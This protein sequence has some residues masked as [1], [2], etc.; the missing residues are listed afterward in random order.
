MT[1]NANVFDGPGLPLFIELEQC[2]FDLAVR[3]GELW[4]RPVDQLTG[5]QQAKIQ[6]HRDELVALVQSYDEGVQERLVAYKQQL[7][8]VPKGSTTD[9]VFQRGTPYAK[10][11]CFSCGAT[12][13][14]LQHG[15]CWRCS[16][17][18]RLAVGGGDPGRA[19]GGV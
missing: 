2:G 1:L 7:A 17:A 19:G 9:F 12:L 6:Q 4:V 8:K 18:W 11:V 3:R 5:A 14:E 13:Q 15:R 10:A 16:L